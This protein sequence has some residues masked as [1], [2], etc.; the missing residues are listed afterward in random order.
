VGKKKRPQIV[1]TISE[2]EKNLWQL[3]RKYHYLNT[4]LN[5]SSRCF[6]LSID[7]RPV[8]FCAIIH[9][10]HPKQCYKKVH[11]LVVLP[12]YQG[13]GLGKIFL[14]K[15][16]ELIN[17]DFAITTSQPALMNSLQNDI[18]WVCSRIGRLGKNSGTL[19]KMAKS[20]S[21]KRITATFIYKGNS[22]NAKK[23]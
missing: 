9:F 13:L 11:R 22:P 1:C 19:K 2:C 4:N 20:A 5:N 16:G 17:Y 14:N 15:I 10:P 6:C 8:A 7:N 21:S 12:D 23:S 3:F 18:N